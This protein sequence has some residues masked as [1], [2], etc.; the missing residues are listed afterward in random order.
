M[1]ISEF[2]V[3]E[4]SAEAIANLKRDLSAF[5]NSLKIN[6]PASLARA[7]S[8]PGSSTPHEIAVSVLEKVLSSLGCKIEKFTPPKQEINPA[9]FDFLFKLTSVLV[10]NPKH[11]IEFMFLSNHGIQL[12]DENGEITAHLKSGLFDIQFINHKLWTQGIIWPMGHMTMGLWHSK[13]TTITLAD[14]KLIVPP[15]D[16]RWFGLKNI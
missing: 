11:D 4:P 16:L 14:Y 5:P 8:S 15:L 1:L 2:E 9:G 6:E 3:Q 13:E 10:E 12:P 7:L